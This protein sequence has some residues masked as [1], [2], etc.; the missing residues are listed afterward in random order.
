MTSHPYAGDGQK[1]G[2]TDEYASTFVGD[3]T[4]TSPFRDPSDLSE[5]EYVSTAEYIRNMEVLINYLHPEKKAA[6]PGDWQRLT[7]PPG[8]MPQGPQKE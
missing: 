3:E 6:G 2:L 5:Q 7:P 8:G 4:D 1:Q